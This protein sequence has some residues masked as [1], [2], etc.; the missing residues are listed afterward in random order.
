MHTSHKYFCSTCLETTV[1]PRLMLQ[2]MHSRHEE[3]FKLNNCQQHFVELT[4]Y[5]CVSSQVP[6]CYVS[7]MEQPFGQKQMEDFLG[8]LIEELRQRRNGTKF[9]YRTSELHLLT[10]TV[11]FPKILQCAECQFKTHDP[12][13]LQRHLLNHNLQLVRLAYPS[14]DHAADAQ[15][16]QLLAAQELMNFMAGK[17]TP[18]SN[19]DSSALKNAKILLPGKQWPSIPKIKYV[20]K[21]LRYTCGVVNCGLQLATE[22][23]LR[24]HL[25]TTH[26][27]IEQVQ[28]KH[29][30]YKDNS[31]SVDKLLEHLANHKRH[32]FQCGACQTFMPRRHLVD[33]HIHERHAGQDVDV[34]IHRRS[35]QS[36]YT[37][38]SETRW[39]KSGKHNF[40]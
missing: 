39:F 4:A 35:D 40:K 12:K 8:R 22:Q 15:H 14:E 32:V 33:R 16:Q 26:M 18:T 7:A 10:R 17:P 13:G 3:Q 28:C 1:N 2:H 37:N 6:K 31:L 23:T 24:Q 20:P 36:I 29:C 27:Y 9:I 25:N 5:H 19:D 34:I 38:Q 11:V 21:E 30:S